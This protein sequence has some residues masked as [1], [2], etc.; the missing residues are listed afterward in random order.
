MPVLHLGYIG[1][2]MVSTDN[3]HFSN[4]RKLPLTLKGV[5]LLKQL[6]QELAG[7]IAS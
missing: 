2:Q 1:L 5:E 6:E 3:I 7:E 4:S